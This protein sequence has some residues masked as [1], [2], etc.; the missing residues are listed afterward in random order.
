MTGRSCIA[1]GRGMDARLRQLPRQGL[2]H[3]ISNAWSGSSRRALLCP[4]KLSLYSR[5]NRG[6]PAHVGIDQGVDALPV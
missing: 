3:G 6:N 4:E 2:K 5:I 1:L